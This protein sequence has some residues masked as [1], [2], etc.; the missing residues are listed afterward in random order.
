MQ[1]KL[2]NVLIGLLLLLAV[3]I[4]GGLGYIYVAYP[5]VNEAPEIKIKATPE[6]LQRGRYLAQYVAVCIDCH[7]RRDWSRFSGPLVQGTE[8]IGGEKFNRELDFPGVVVAPNITPAALKD[9]S[10]G[11]MVRAITEGVSQDGRAL[12]PLMPYPRYGKTDK[13]DIYAIVAYLRTL[14]AKKSKKPYPPR[15]LDFPLNLIVRLMPETARLQPRPARKKTVAYGGYLASLAAC[16]ACHTP[17]GK[18]ATKK[19]SGGRAFGVPSGGTVYASNLTPD[20]QTG[21]GAWKKEAFVQRFQ[22]YAPPYK[23]RPIQKGQFNTVMP[24]TMYGAMKKEDLGAI[25]DYLRSLPP[26]QR[27]VTPFKREG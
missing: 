6:R 12:F 10:D 17:Q 22:T 4:G 5:R 18:E 19:L 1:Q 21:L 20:R 26:I 24:W 14:P 25:F 11:E 7:S 8:G 3:L 27:K 15:K 9:W 2:L 23:A 16:G 13:K